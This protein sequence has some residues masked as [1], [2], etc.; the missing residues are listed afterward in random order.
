MIWQKW[1]CLGLE[2]L[3]FSNNNRESMLPAGAESKYTAIPAHAC[4]Q[5]QKPKQK[6]KEIAGIQKEAQDYSQEKRDRLVS[7]MGVELL[8]YI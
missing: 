1:L 5:T 2:G 7:L 4:V 8:I 3:T 6:R